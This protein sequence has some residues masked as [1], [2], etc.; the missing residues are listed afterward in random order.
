[1]RIRLSLGIHFPH[2][3]APFS[4]VREE[5]KKLQA[6]NADLKKQLTEAQKELSAKMKEVEDAKV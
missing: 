2:V 5:L 4:Q 6:E 1:M 3:A